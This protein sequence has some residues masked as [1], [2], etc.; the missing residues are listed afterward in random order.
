M[1][2]LPIQAY[3]Y[4]KMKIFTRSACKQNIKSTYLPSAIIMGKINFFQGK[5]YAK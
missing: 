4:I 3:S 2:N 5:L 1:N